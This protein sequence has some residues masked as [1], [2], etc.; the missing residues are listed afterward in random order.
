MHRTVVPI[1]LCC[2]LEPPKVHSFALVTVNLAAEAPIRAISRLLALCIVCLI[3][4]SR[5]GSTAI[6][7]VRLLRNPHP[8][9]HRYRRHEHIRGDMERKLY[10]RIRGNQAQNS[11]FAVS[12]CGRKLDLGLVYTP[13]TTRSASLSRDDDTSDID[14]GSL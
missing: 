14:N 4:R 9:D 3:T 7:H 5:C 6:S 12:R 13:T 8:A 2:P 11:K 1:K 10:D